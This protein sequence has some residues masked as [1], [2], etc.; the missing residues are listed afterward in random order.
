MSS[1]INTRI[2]SGVHDRQ[3]ADNALSGIVG[4]RLTYRQPDLQQ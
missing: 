1:G 4:K 2:A 3:R